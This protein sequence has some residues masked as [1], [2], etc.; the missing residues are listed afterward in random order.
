MSFQRLHTTITFSL[1]V[2]LPKKEDYLGKL[3]EVEVVETGKHYMRG[4][5]L[6]TSPPL[7][8][9][10]V[11]PLARGAVSLLLLLNLSDILFYLL[12]YFQQ[13]FPSND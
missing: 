10:S 3:V 1:Q 11:E 12:V 9:S 4:R 5:P 2:L 8:P 13:V 7:P 6:D